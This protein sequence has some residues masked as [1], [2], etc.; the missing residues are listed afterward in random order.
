MFESLSLLSETVRRIA[1]R[2]NPRQVVL[3]GSRARGEAGP[4]SDFDLLVIADSPEPRY[5]RSAPL[6]SLLADLPVEIEVVVYTPE[7]V[8]EWRGVRQS[9]VATAL[10]EGVVVYEKQD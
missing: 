7:E 2:M 4:E 6:Y 9:F 3:F 10:R 8:E 1:E 5:R